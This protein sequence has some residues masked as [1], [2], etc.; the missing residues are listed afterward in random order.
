LKL[1]Q[2]KT[3][4]KFAFNFIWCRYM[5]VTDGTDNQ[6]VTHKKQFIF[7]NESEAG[8]CYAH[9]LLTSTSAVFSLKT[10]QKVISSGQKLDGFAQL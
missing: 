9:P 4:S 10:P 8:D 7:Y 3:I 1:E 6:L 2:E 5:K